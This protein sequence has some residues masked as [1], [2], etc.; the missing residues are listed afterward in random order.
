MDSEKIIIYGFGNPGRQ[1]DGLGPAL[2]SRLEE[3]N[4]QNIKTESN[5]QLNIEDALLISEF[6]T[7]IFIDASVNCKE[8]FS[9]YEIEDVEEFTFTTHS[10]SPGSVLALCKKLFGKYVKSFI[11]EIRGYEWSLA[12]GLSPMAQENFEK[13]YDFL[14]NKVNELLTEEIFNSN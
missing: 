8:P 2:I 13:A 12:E 6:S 11:L 1:D 3:E 10:I 5:Y 4:I 9:Y 14:R 7:V